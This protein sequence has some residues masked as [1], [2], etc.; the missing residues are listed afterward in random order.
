[1][2]LDIHVVTTVRLSVLMSDCAQLQYTINTTKKSYDNLSPY[3]QTTIAHICHMLS[4]LMLV[5]L[6]V[7]CEICQPLS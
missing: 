3:L 4:K 7:W 2:D 6:N 5:I 1:M